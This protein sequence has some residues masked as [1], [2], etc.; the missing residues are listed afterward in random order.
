LKTEAAKI[1]STDFVVC[2]TMGHSTDRPVLETIFKQNV[3]P[4]CLGVIGSK[5]K[6]AALLRELLADDGIDREV[7]EAFI[8]PIGLSIRSN[9]PTEI[10]LSIVA[11]LFGSRD[12]QRA[13]KPGISEDSARETILEKRLTTVVVFRTLC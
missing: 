2:M 13:L 10:A 6:R 5:S 9:Q 12:R 3:T 11:Q 4:A 7:A 8:C 1:R